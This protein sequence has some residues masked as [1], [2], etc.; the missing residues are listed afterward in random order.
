SACT[1]SLTSNARRATPRCTR[2]QN[3]PQP[4]TC[5]WKT[6]CQLPAAPLDDRVGYTLAMKTLYQA[7]NAVEAHMLADYLKQEGLS[8]HVLGEHLQGAVGE[9]PA[10]GLV[11]LMIPDE[12]YEA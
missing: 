2:W 1:S 9:L 3:W 10:A 4:C 8:A 5:R 11:R 6:S 12:Q 7:A